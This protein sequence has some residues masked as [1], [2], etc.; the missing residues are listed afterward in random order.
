MKVLARLCGHSPHQTEKLL[1]R[2]VTL[3]HVAWHLPPQARAV[4]Q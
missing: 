4:Q 3:A 1:D 2:L